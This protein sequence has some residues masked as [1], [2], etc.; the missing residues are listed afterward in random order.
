MA[1]KVRGKSSSLPASLSHPRVGTDLYPLQT[2][3]DHLLGTRQSAKLKGT[4]IKN[5][6]KN[7]KRLQPLILKLLMDTFIKMCKGI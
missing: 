4:Q 6:N 3:V 1:G 7:N 2:S 5:K